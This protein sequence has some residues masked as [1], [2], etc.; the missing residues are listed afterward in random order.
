MSE[1]FFNKTVSRIKSGVGII[2][3][4]RE[5]TP[6]EKEY[7]F[8]AALTGIFVIALVS[9]EVLPGEVARTLE[10]V[11]QLYFYLLPD[12]LHFEVILGGEVA[13]SSAI[14]VDGAR[15]MAQ[16]RAPYL[17][18]LITILKQDLTFRLKPP[19]RLS[20]TK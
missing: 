17:H 14:T 19:K 9:P 5:N 18:A 13:L 20:K 2:R 16:E 7:F 15:R 4:L 1:N 10:T 12:R 3:G 11:K 8:G 6:P